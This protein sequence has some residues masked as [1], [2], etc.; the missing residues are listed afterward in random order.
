MTP[1]KK[2]IEVALPLDATN[3]EAAEKIA[4]LHTHSGELHLPSIRRS[5]AASLLR[6]TDE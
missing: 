4:D 2:F 3:R 6:D 1:L 5:Q